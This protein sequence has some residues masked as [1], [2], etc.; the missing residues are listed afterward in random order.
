MHPARRTTWDNSGMPDRDAETHA[1]DGWPILP[2]RTA[3]DLEDWLSARHSNQ[4]GLWV[5]FAKKDR[6]IPS[7]TL[8]EA[9]EVAMCFGWVDSKMHGLDDDYYILRFQPRRPKSNWSARNK[10]LVER[11]IAEGRMRPAGQAEV[12]RAKADGRW[13][14]EESAT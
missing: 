4:P 8:P 5:K 7:V 12:D 1:S 9:V 10:E 2:F 14:E 11:L 13:G 6:G 3:Q